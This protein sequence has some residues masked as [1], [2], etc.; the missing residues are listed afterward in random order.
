LLED[1][2]LLC[3]GGKI[4]DLKDKKE[5]FPLLQDVEIIDAKGGYVVPGYIDIH[6]HG[7]GGA[8]VMDGEYEALK[9][10]AVTHSRFGTTSFVPATMTMSKEKIIK[11]LD[12][13]RLTKQKGTGAAEILGINLEGPFISS[14]KKGA[15]KEENIKKA[16]QQEFLE[17]NSAAG[18]L[19]RLV[20]IAPEMPG[21]LEFIR[22][23]HQQG[24]IVAVGHS[25]ATYQ[26]TLEGIQAGISHV[27]H[28]FNAMRGVHH[29]EPGVAGA[30]LTFPDLTVEMIADGIHL[31]PVILKLLTQVIGNEKLILVT[32]AM[33]AAGF[34][35]GT[36]DLG[37]QEVTVAQGEA[38][39]ADGTLAGSVLT[40]EK[41]VK[42]MVTKAGVS[43]L[44]ALQMASYNPAKCLGL[45]GKKGSLEQGKD[46]DIV[47]LNMDLE[48]D[49]T[50]VSGE[51]VFQK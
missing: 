42:N 9:K 2:A 45:H 33:R 7:G 49:L 37:G 20:T 40:M 19:I 51:V 47:I 16:S 11:S 26:Q 3:E 43:L 18:N 17:Y 10:I 12:N 30:A 22:W 15:Q 39:L 31:H 36:Y 14:E 34:K 38:R 8:D 23:L 6:I 27:T 28:V 29:R 25:N 41:A 50:M 13:I 44:N 48:A 32:D 35:A 24:I 46:A 21:A 1:K 5:S 4:L